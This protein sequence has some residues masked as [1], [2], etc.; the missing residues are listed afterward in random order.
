VIFASEELDEGDWRQF[1]TPEIISATPTK[2]GIAL[3]RRTFAPR[4]R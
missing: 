1:R 3:S 4:S 2:N